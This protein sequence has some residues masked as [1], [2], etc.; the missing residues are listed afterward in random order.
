VLFHRCAA[1]NWRPVTS[2][3]RKIVI[4]VSLLG[5]NPA[6]AGDVQVNGFPTDADFF[7]IGV[8]L[9]SPSRAPE[10]SAIGI[11]TFVG[12]HNGPTEQQLALLARHHMFAVAGQNEVALESVNRNTI[13]AWM[14]DDE[15]DNAQPIGLGLYGTCIPATEVTRRTQEIKARDP[16]RPV[17]INFG[18]GVANEFWRGRGP[19]NGDQGYYDV[20][21]R[22]A[23]IL[24]YD[25]YP[26]GSDTPQV[27]GRLEYVARGVTNLL[28]RASNGQRVWM[29][30]ETTALDPT[31]GPTA[32]EVRSEVWMALIHGATGI[33]YFV[34]EFKPDFREDAIFRYP[35]IVA[36]VT[37]TNKLIKSL[38]PALR[39]PGVS[40]A[41]TVSSNVPVATMVKVYQDTTYIF[42][43]A[44]QNAPSTA[45]FAIND[46]HQT[47]ARVIG[48]DRNLSI[49]QGSF[50][51]H[52]EG[53]G[54]HLYQ[55]PAAA[56]R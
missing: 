2:F 44:M 26:V 21:I 25:I 6:F 35:D 30:L 45:R 51:D 24:S 33:F 19:C 47:S 53:Y 5:G 42:A 34:H 49:A 56:P 7:P 28:K 13:K 41:I 18:Q 39:S 31:R 43:V 11:N 22:G 12:L 32:A 23:D 27:K 40:G 8:W 55:L 4:M 14:Q 29:A 38:S 46:L 52:F 36:E 9:Q 20:A 15:P 54:V 16:T 37:R 1:I 3:G 48:E 10:Y 50:E 17:M